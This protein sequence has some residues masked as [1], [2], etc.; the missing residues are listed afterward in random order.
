MS[1]KYTPVKIY[2][3]GGSGMEWPMK[4]LKGSNSWGGGGGGGVVFSFFARGHGQPHRKSGVAATNLCTRT[5]AGSCVRIS[6]K[7][8]HTPGA[9]VAI[10]AASHHFP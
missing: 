6:S 4:W 5:N 9:E 1:L 7:H 3:K 2:F 10:S 8:C